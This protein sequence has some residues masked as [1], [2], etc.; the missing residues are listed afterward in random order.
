[1]A[2]ID[3]TEVVARI[4]AAGRYRSV[5]PSL[6]HSLAMVESPKAKNLA[7]AEKRTRRRLHQIF[8]AYVGLKAPYTAMRKELQAASGEAGAL[9]DACRSVMRHHASTRERLPIVESFYPRIFERL[10]EVG[11]IVDLACGLNPLAIPWMP[12]GPGVGYF[13]YDIDAD[14]MG[15]LGDAMELM[16]R[17]GKAELR[18][19]V[20]N[21]PD[22]AGD[23]ALLLKS[24]PCLE[25]QSPGSGYRL[26]EQSPAPVV[27]VSYPTRSLG[28]AER[29]MTRTYRAEFE[30]HAGGKP[31]QSEMI[32]FDGELVFIVRKLAQ[33]GLPG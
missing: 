17:A 2:D 8:G 30:A 9:R 3:V 12:I 27:I 25:R 1:M 15:F 22:R 16:G 31:W 32:E 24:V 13:A 33:A 5:D 26:I 10:G 20:G 6:V 7:E 21:V 28:G 23:V 4:G 29:G 14:L 19:V 11:T 18:D